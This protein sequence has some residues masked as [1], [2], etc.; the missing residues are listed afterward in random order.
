MLV[1]DCW[2]FAYRYQLFKCILAN[3]FKQTIACFFRIRCLLNHNQG[4]I[5]QATQQIKNIAL[6]HPVTA[7]RFRSF[8]GK[9]ARED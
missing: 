6:L 4:F 1:T 5:H 3:R 9:P 8:E 7:N 2:R